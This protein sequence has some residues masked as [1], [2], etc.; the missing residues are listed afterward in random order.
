MEGVMI[1]EEELSDVGYPS[2]KAP[3]YIVLIEKYFNGIEEK[4]RSADSPEKANKIVNDTC[5]GFEQEC[6]SEI[7]P[8]FLWGYVW[9]IFKSYWGDQK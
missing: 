3:L 5:Q 9:D 6:I 2:A 4:I 8:I 7:I 1:S